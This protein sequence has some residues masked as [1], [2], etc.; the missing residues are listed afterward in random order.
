MT[1]LSRGLLAISLLTAAPDQGKVV[2]EKSIAAHGGL[3]RFEAIRDWKIVA[4][5]NTDS[6]GAETYEEYLLRDQGGTRTLLMKKQ[7]E[8]VLVFGHDGSRGFAVAE[9][10]L[11]TDDGAEGEGYYRAHG[12]YYL[13]SLPFKWMDPGLEVA[14]A[15]AEDRFELLRISASKNVGRA[16]EDVWVAV[17]DRD[18]SLLFEARL[19]HH[20]GR[21]TWMSPQRNEVTEITYRYSD[22]RDVEGLRIPFRMEY[23]SNGRKTG[24]NVIQSIDFDSGLTAEIFSPQAHFR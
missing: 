11:R 13:R 15:G 12:E 5:R 18:T 19:T 8:S 16:W 2:L 14:Y 4:R 9:G 10:A 22:Y 21:E 23:V 6:G 1:T 20:R 3:A 17:I 7:A 24:E